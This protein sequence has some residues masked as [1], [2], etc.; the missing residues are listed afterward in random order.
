MLQKN[1]I[2]SEVKKE[3]A[4]HMVHEYDVSKR[5]ACQAVQLPG[6]TYDYAP[7]VDATGILITR[8]LQE[9]IQTHPSIG[10]WMCHH[11]LRIKEYKRNH[12]RVYRTILPDA[13]KHRW[14]GPKDRE[15]YRA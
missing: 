6:S 9:L 8:K 15:V 7:R 5:L 1:G 12:K 3:P 14:R 11:R 4:D 10:S 13:V 2:G